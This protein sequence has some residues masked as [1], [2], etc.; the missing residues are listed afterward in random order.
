LT[1][2]KRTFVLPLLPLFFF[3]ESPP[4]SIYPAC[5]SLSLRIEPFDLRFDPRHYRVSCRLRVPRQRIEKMVSL[6]LT[7]S[8]SR[9]PPSTS[10]SHLP[11][12]T[13]Q[14]A[15]I[16][17]YNTTN[18]HPYSRPQSLCPSYTNSVAP[19]SAPTYKSSHRP[20]SLE[21]LLGSGSNFERRE[22]GSGSASRKRVSVIQIENGRLKRRIL[23][24]DS[25]GQ[26]G[27]GLRERKKSYGIGG[28]G[29]IR[30]YSFYFPSFLFLLSSIWV[31]MEGV[32]T[33]NQ[34]DHQK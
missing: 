24:M 3:Y 22:S 15:N 19:S 26:E 34:E 18:S 9:R 20:E 1:A 25:H 33:S 17:Q 12:P 2:K 10:S 5:R 32:L 13:P 21:H 11:S 7:I 27:E 8:I 30:M 14:P 28:A 4:F 31:G 23:S 16:S 29:N 6:S